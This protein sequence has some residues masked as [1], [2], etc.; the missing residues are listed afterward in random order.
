MLP[1]TLGVFMKVDIIKSGSLA[2]SP[3]E[4]VVFS[5]GDKFKL[6]D[7]N[8]TETNLKRLV[9]LKYAEFSEGKIEIE[10]EK[11][12]LVELDEAPSEI[13]TFDNKDELEEYAREIYDVELDKRQSLKKMKETL[14][15]A[16]EGK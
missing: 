15:T 1:L 6:G 4:V 13:D 14:K 8:L 11:I 16:I 10:E 2:I 9:E 7:K 12:E 5:K 3:R